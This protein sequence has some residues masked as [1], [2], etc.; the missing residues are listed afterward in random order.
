LKLGIICALFSII[1]KPYPGARPLIRTLLI[2]TIPF[3]LYNLISL[4]WAPKSK[5]IWII[6]YTF[7]SRVVIWLALMFIIL[8]AGV[9]H[10]HLQIDRRLK[11]ILLGFLAY[12][13]PRA[14]IKILAGI[15]PE[16]DHWI[17]SHINQL[18][19]LP[20]LLIWNLAFS[21]VLQRDKSPE[22]D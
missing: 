6:A 22:D 19:I 3:L 20:P 10:F 16:D 7:D 13:A 17:F 14:I 2:L 18:L 4:C 11:Y 5:L 1:Y 12:Q 21:S 8:A 15:L 9:Y